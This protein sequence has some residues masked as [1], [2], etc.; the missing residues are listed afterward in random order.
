MHMP[1]FEVV[2][3]IAAPPQRVFDASLDVQVHTAS[4][5]G[6]AED[7]VGGITERWHHGRCPPE[8]SRRSG[9]WNDRGLRH[10][11]AA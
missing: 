3:P 7:A 5:A 11:Q 6:S 2:T 9:Q 10:V 8:A 1:R 4:M